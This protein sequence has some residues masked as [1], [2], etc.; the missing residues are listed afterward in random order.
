MMLFNKWFLGVGGWKVLYIYNDYI[1]IYHDH[2]VIICIYIYFINKAPAKNI[3][4]QVPPNK[5]GQT[6]NSKG[7]PDELLH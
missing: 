7:F 1:Y 3:H 6:L 2:I 5:G 4:E